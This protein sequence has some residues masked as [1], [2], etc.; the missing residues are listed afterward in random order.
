MKEER[1]HTK[2]IVQFQSAYQPEQIWEFLTHPKYAVAFTKDPCYHNEVNASF[3]L[4]PGNQWTEIHTGE[5]CEGDVVLCTIIESTINKAFTTVRHQA[6]IKNT[7][8]FKLEKNQAGTI[9]TEIQKFSLSGRKIR[10][11]NIFSW[12]M[13]GTGL[14]TKFS[15]KPEDDFYW[16]EQMEHKLD[17]VYNSAL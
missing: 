16:F 7:T 5:D 17:T 12:M 9:I 11:I 13:L 8:L 14:L 15:F 3:K 2:T 4:E 10:P 6:G 1:K